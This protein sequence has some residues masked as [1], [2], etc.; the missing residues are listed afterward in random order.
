MSVIETVTGNLVGKLHSVPI[1]FFNGVK[2]ENQK[3]KN[4]SIIY[5]YYKTYYLFSNAVKWF[6]ILAIWFFQILV[7]NLESLNCLL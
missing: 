1:E 6:K 4:N 2:A 7:F 5:F 3:L